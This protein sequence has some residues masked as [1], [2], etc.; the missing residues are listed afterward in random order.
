MDALL[1]SWSSGAGARSQSPLL[2]RP[3]SLSTASV[4][5]DAGVGH[6]DRACPSAE[7]G[8]PLLMPRPPAT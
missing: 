1:G 7:V 8:A 5:R 4:P 3:R 2:R 6:E